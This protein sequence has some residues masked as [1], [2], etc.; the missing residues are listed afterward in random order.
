MCSGSVSESTPNAYEPTTRAHG[1]D[2]VGARAQSRVDQVSDQLGVGV[3]RDRMAVRLELGAQLAVVLHD[4][5]VHHH[6]RPRL[7]R[8]R[9]AL[10]RLAVRG[11]A[12]V[13]DA[14]ATGD[15]AVAE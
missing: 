10:G 6:D 11:P 15:R 3:G 1:G 9:V 14:D 4:A 13:T 5:V 12:R 7:V 2:Q 8:M